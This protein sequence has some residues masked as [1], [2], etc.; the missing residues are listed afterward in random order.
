[1][2]YNTLV[3]I[4]SDGVVG[5]VLFF[6]LHTLL[7]DEVYSR[8]LHIAWVKIY[9]R[10]IRTIIP[11]AVALEVNCG[12]SDVQQ[13]REYEDCMFPGH[14][15]QAVVRPSSQHAGGAGSDGGMSIV[16]PVSTAREVGDQGEQLESENLRCAS[17]A[18]S[19][20]CRHALSAKSSHRISYF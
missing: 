19:S 1:M 3:L 12:A 17:L 6:V 15:A 16:T 4:F 8:D 11:V 10:M 7:G 13:D 5:E 9:N 2:L 20:S 18:A 14:Q